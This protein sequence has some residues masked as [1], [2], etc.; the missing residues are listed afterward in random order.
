VR[1]ITIPADQP[2]HKGLGSKTITPSR[3]V[4]VFF[5]EAAF[6]HMLSATLS[7]TYRVAT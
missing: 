7:M 5:G 1:G 4:G 2:V 3:R 6:R